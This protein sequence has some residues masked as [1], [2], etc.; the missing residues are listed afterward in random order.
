MSEI[1]EDE[2]VI[3][4]VTENDGAIKGIE[5]VQT[6]LKNL[7]GSIGANGTFKLTELANSLKAINGISGKIKN[8]SKVVGTFNNLGNI[9]YDHI[10]EGVTHVAGSFDA[11][12]NSLA[13]MR[14]STNAVESLTASLSVLPGALSSFP[15]SSTITTDSQRISS[16]PQRAD[17]NYTSLMRESDKDKAKE[18]HGKLL[19]KIVQDR[20][21]KRKAVSIRAMITA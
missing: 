1:E 18:R 12:K 7:D 9:D 8:L 17:S 16:N 13:G 6:A 4:V 3:K 20:D 2:L 10:S 11:L 19:A 15:D 5:D 21:K 14:K